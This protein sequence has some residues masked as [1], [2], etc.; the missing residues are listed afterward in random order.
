[1]PRGLL[2]RSEGLSLGQ[3]Q[4]GGLYGNGEDGSGLAASGQDDRHRSQGEARDGD[5]R[6]STRGQP[7]SSIATRRSRLPDKRMRIPAPH[8]R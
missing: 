1:M 5:G 4:R 8:P 6:L 7:R 3:R 2:G